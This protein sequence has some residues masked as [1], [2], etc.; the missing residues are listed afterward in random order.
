MTKN[1]ISCIGKIYGALHKVPLQILQTTSQAS[2]K[3]GARKM[4]QPMVTSKKVSSICGSCFQIKGLSLY[5]FDL[6]NRINGKKSSTL[7]NPHTRYVQFAPCH[8]PHIKNTIITFLAIISFFLPS[9]VHHTLYTTL[10]R[11][12]PNG[13]YT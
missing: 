9:T 5:R 4:I 6:P 13:I 12:P 2:A 10:G 3:D 8:S 7:Y 1:S 11:E